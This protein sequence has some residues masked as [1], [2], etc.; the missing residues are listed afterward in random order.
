MTGMKPRDLILESKDRREDI[1]DRVEA[2]TLKQSR[3][4]LDASFI[5]ISAARHSP[6]GARLSGVYGVAVTI[7]VRNLVSRLCGA[8]SVALHC[9][10]G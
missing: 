4:V 2:K 10:L 8:A 6:G 7:L 3:T 5:V 9:I 1:L